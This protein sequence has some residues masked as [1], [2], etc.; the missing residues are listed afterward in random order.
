ML[1]ASKRPAKPGGPISPQ[2]LLRLSE[3]RRRLRYARVGGAGAHNF[4]QA[5]IVHICRRVPR[6]ELGSRKA[7]GKI[8]EGTGREPVVFGTYVQVPELPERGL[9][10]S[11]RP[12]L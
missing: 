7:L 9:R 11:G 3:V 4:I 5:F 6:V 8:G 1:R 12:V 2:P 10:R